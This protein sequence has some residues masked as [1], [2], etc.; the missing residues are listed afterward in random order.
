MTSFNLASI[1]IRIIG[2]YSLIISF[3]FVGSIMSSYSVDE[4]RIYF[5]LG[6]LIPFLLLALT[7]ILLIVFSN[8]LA[9][10]MTR[11]DD[12]TDSGETALNNLHVL[13]FSC[14]GLIIA[15]WPIPKLIYVGSNIYVLKNYSDEMTSFV[16]KKTVL[17]SYA[18]AFGYILQIVLGLAIFIGS[19]GLSKVWCILQKT[20]PMGKANT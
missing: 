18:Y 3:P 11:S 4:D 19:K 10:K 15:I 14:V 5:F 1:L 17:E 9:R 8:S 2:I 16:F 7:G 20:R 12:I 6:S 13:I